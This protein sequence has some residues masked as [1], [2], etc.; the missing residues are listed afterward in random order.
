MGACYTRS[1]P[2]GGH[3]AV[4]GV[5]ACGLLWLNP[6]QHMAGCVASLTEGTEVAGAACFLLVHNVG[7]LDTG[8]SACRATTPSP[9]PATYEPQVVVLQCGYGLCTC[10]H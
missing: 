3:V 10:A 7:G 6:G 9:G 1:G 5:E 8:C 4:L 2:T